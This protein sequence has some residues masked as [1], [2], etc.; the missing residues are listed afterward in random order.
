[1]KRIICMLLLLSSIFAFCGASGESVSGIRDLFQVPAVTSTPA[2][3]AFR[4][5][6]GIRWGMN[7]QQVKALETSPMTERAMQNWSIM[8]TDAKVSVSR[9]AA[10]LVFMFLEDRL[11][12]IS[13]EF[14]N[15]SAE[16]FLYLSGAL[17]SV[18]GE[19][20]EAEPQKIKTLMDLV[21][22]NRYKTELITQA[23]GWK[24]G[25]GTLVYLYY[26]SPDTFAILYV[27]PG[28]YQTNGL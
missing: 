5:R 25:D 18:Y 4:F 10:D 6:D 21:N 3:N 26:F 16:D 17:A 13:Y 20:Q 22:P 2:P 23:H 11:Q 1:M 24:T 9:F 8:L 12:M 14:P 28:I 27:S 15:G 19:K 7:T